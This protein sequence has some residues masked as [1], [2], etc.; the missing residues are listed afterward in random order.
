[1]RLVTVIS[2]VEYNII[3]VFC[4]SCSFLFLDGRIFLFT[5][6]VKVEMKKKNVNQTTYKA[7]MPSLARNKN[8]SIH[9]LS[10]KSCLCIFMTQNGRA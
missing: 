1:M 5:R 10:Q 6:D 4:F 7:T 8:L 2:R 3:G 9:F